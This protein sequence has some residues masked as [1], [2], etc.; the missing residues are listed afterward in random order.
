MASCRIWGYFAILKEANGQHDR[1]FP[2][3]AL[4]DALEVIIIVVTE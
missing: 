1:R 4:P 2:F 3:L